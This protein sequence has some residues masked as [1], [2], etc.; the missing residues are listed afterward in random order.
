MECMQWY[1]G[2]NSPLEIVTLV[3]EFPPVIIS[4]AIYDKGK[5][6]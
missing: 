3:L 5:L 4:S 1:M 6:I 2:I